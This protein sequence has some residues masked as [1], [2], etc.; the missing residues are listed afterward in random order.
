MIRVHV[1]IASAKV[2]EGC[3]HCDNDCLKVLI[4]DLGSLVPRLLPSLCR[5]LYSWEEPGNEARIL[6][7]Y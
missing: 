1:N 2:E 5:I 3:V 4:W 7:Q 6:V